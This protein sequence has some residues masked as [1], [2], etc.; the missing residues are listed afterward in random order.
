[1]RVELVFNM[2]LLLLQKGV[3]I[4]DYYW[5]KYRSVIGMK[6]TNGKVNPK[7]WN[8]PKGKEMSADQTGN[9]AIFYRKLVQP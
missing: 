7:L 6:Q 5:D 2:T 1:M 4:F 3:D 9:W 8:D